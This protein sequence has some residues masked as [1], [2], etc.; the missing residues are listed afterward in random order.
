MNDR[1]MRRLYNLSIGIS[2][3]IIILLILF[4]SVSK[5]GTVLD[6]IETQI[7]SS[8]SL[9]QLIVTIV[10]TVLWGIN[11]APITKE[12]LKMKEFTVNRHVSESKKVKKD[13]DEE[14]RRSYLMSKD[15]FVTRAWVK[16]KQDVYFAKEIYI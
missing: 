1:N 6:V 9:M 10:Y 2:Y 11:I 7:I 8:V 13:K 16:V 3:L 4:Y 12:K 15:N 14:K 5:A